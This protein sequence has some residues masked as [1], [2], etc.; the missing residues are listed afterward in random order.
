MG[1]CTAFYATDLRTFVGKKNLPHR[2]T[3]P[4]SIP[5]KYYFASPNIGGGHLPNPCGVCQDGGQIKLTIYVHNGRRFG[6]QLSNVCTYTGT[7]VEPLEAINF[8]KATSWL[9]A[10]AH[11]H[12]YVHSGIKDLICTYV[13]FVRFIVRNIGIGLKK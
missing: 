6:S 10:P 4:S 11:G 13:L 12:M 9:H 8:Y 7:Y 5:T 3:L 2:P 1:K